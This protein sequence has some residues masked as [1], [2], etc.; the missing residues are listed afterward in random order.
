MKENYIENKM[1][2]K[3]MQINSVV[4]FYKNFNF[5]FFFASPSS[6]QIFPNKWSYY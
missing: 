1:C 5:L 6:L 4:R 2:G 3:K